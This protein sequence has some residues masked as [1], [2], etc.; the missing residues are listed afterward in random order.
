MIRV[1]RTGTVKVTLIPQRDPSKGKRKYT[2]VIETDR[3]NM[4]EAN[5]ANRVIHTFPP[6]LLI[7]QK[8]CQTCT[9]KKILSTFVF[10]K[11]TEHLM[12]LP[13]LLEDS[14]TIRTMGPSEIKCTK[15]LSRVETKLRG[16][17]IT[18]EQ[19]KRE[20]AIALAIELF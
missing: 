20:Q 19:L 8:E 18:K 6:C 12:H 10:S 15:K 3:N 16:C 11:H 17:L 9:G 1:Q 13:R 14:N 2:L 5:S 7:K 4:I